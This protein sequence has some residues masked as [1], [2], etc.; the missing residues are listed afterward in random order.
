MST[1]WT[2]RGRTP[3]RCPPQPPLTAS[4]S[5]AP[6]PRGCGAGHSRNRS[7]GRWPARSAAAAR[8]SSG[9]LTISSHRNQN[10]QDR[11]QRHQRGLEGAVQLRTAAAQNPDTR[12]HDHERQQR[13]DAHQFA[14]NADGDEGGEDGHEDAHRDRGNIRACGSADGCGR[15]IRGSRPS[16]DME[17]N[18]RDWPSSMTSITVLNPMIVPIS[19]RYSPQATP[20]ACHPER[21]G[22]GHVRAAGI[23]PRR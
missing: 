3:D 12:A 22:R 9:R 21:D 17:K 13:P 14:Q 5:A 7:P 19:T 20:V 8:C 11:H 15:P 2:S 4:S 6:R 23:S 10:S 16:R 1:L 18:T